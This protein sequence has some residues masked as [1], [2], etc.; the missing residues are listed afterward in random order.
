MDIGGTAWRFVGLADPYQ[1]RRTAATDL[2][3][4]AALGEIKVEEDLR[5]R[6]A[7][8]GQQNAQEQQDW[9]TDGATGHG[10]HPKGKNKKGGQA[11]GSADKV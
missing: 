7:G 3:L 5:R 11:A 2:E 9:T 1:A 4:E 10:T 8:V 6:C